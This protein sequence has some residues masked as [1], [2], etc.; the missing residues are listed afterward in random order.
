MKKFISVLLAVVMIFSIGSVAAFAAETYEV[1]FTEFPY[2]VSPYRNDYVGKYEG[3]EY[4][5][6]YWFTITNA[7]GTTTDI[8]GFPYS[9]QVDAG[10]V[11]EFVVNLADYIE[12]TSVKV[13]AFPKGTENKDDFYNTV[14]GEP[15]G[16]YYVKSTSIGTYGVAPRE[17]MTV[18]LSEFH[19]YNKAFLY[20]FPTSEYYK[21]NRLFLTDPDATNI[22]DRFSY[23]DR[24]NT[25]VIYMN[26]TVFFEVR[27]PLEDGKTKYNR[28]TYHVYYTDGNSLLAEKIYLKRPAS[29]KDGTEEIDKKI[30]HYETET[31]WVDIYAVPNIPEDSEIKIANTVTYNISMLGEFLA[32]FD[33]M[34][35][36]SID[37]STVDIEP[38]LGYILR[39]VNL[40]VKLLNSFGLNITLPDLLG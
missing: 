26:E 13:M 12:P 23:S 20:E 39:L 24:D 10:K 27:L 21:A 28:D 1:V 32:D 37:L 5:V 38:M 11:V 31:E 40:V 33:L 29:E 6:D 18:C 34:N 19:L 25:E 14:S 15:D 36:D 17:D 22:E 9:M 16:R 35:L 30:G 2:D 4:G 3:Y 7:D 8:K